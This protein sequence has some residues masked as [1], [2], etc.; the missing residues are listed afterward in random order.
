MTCVLHSKEV[1]DLSQSS[2]KLLLIYLAPYTSRTFQCFNLPLYFI[3]SLLSPV[4]ILFLKSFF[5]SI[6]YLVLGSRI[7]L[8]LSNFVVLFL[9]CLLDLAIRLFWIFMLFYHYIVPLIF[10]QFLFSMFRFTFLTDRFSS[11]FSFPK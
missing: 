4:L 1:S 10:G 3:R 5:T 7:L 9:F 6:F 11:I 2:N 8:L